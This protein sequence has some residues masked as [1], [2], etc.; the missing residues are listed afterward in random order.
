MQ[1]NLLSK[2]NVDTS[3]FLIKNIK[4]ITILFLGFTHC[5]IVVDQH[6]LLWIKT[7]FNTASIIGYSCTNWGLLS[8]YRH[9]VIVDLWGLTALLSAL[10]NHFCHIRFD[11]AIGNKHA[12]LFLTNLI[13]LITENGAPF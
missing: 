11:F 1:P 4:S 9:S 3:M 7:V 10:L 12:L 8:V 5:T 2:R 13:D 6:N